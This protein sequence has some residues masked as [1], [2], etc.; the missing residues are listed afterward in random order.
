MLKVFS[1][2][3]NFRKVLDYPMWPSNNCAKSIWSKPDREPIKI[4]VNVAC[5]LESSSIVVVA[6]DWRG[7]VLFVC[8]KRMNTTFPLQAEVEAII[9]ALNL[10]LNLDVGSIYI[11][12]DSNP[13][14]MC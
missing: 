3:A 4:N 8:S 2:V 12:S 14:L 1:F 6:R 10:A 13:G 5:N 9:Q 11:E 7:E